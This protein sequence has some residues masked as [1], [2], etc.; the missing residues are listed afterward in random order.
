MCAR[1]KGRAGLWL[2]EKYIE[3]R[4]GHQIML[5]LKGA[6]TCDLYCV[7]EKTTVKDDAKGTL[8]G[9]QMKGS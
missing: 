6:A 8:N 3:E 9:L 1:Q 2:D 4:G 5:L 7:S